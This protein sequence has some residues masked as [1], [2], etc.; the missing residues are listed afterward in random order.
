[1]ENKIIKV[2]IF[3]DE[4]KIENIHNLNMTSKICINALTTYTIYLTHYI[5]YD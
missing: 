1:M 4:N 3:S 5:K 2:Y